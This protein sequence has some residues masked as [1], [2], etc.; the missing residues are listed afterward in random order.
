LSN[1][2]FTSRYETIERFHG[3]GKRHRRS[4]VA[5]GGMILIEQLIDRMYVKNVN[6]KN[7]Q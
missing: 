1:S 6:F 2:V 5:E 4:P 3:I 7:K